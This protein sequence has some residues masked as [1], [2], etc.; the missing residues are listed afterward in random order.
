M[1]RRELPQIVNTS[2][3]STD[4]RVIGQ[5]PERC[6]QKFSKREICIVNALVFNAPALVNGSVIQ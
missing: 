6:R 3:D 1:P 5:S 2:S 4:I